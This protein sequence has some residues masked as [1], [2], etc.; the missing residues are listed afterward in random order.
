MTWRAPDELIEQ[1]RRI[2]EQHGWSMNEMV[3][4]ALQAATDPESADDDV[5]RLRERLDRAGLLA[6]AGQ[7]RRRPE[8]ARV[9]AARRSAGHGRPVSDLVSEQRG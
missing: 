7:S 6:P 2:A 4:R 8:A 9:A 5:Q 1:V 3:T